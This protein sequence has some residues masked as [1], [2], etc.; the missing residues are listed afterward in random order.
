LFEEA[1]KDIQQKKPLGVSI[2]TPIKSILPNN[3]GLDIKNHFFGSIRSINF[4]DSSK[5]T[6]IIISTGSTGITKSTGP[7]KSTNVIGFFGPIENTNI[8][9]FSKNIGSTKNSL[10]LEDITQQL[11]RSKHTFTLG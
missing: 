8:S 9:G 11:L 3:F 4:I 1:I 5:S 2:Q 7:T 10:V 6:S